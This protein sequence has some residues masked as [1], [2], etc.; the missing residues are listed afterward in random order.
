[1]VTIEYVVCS[2]DNTHAGHS[3]LFRT[4]LVNEDKS[5]TAGFN[6]VYTITNIMKIDIHKM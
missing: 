4:L 5:F 6:G 2:I 3:K 1:M